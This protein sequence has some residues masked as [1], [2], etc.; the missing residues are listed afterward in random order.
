MI[1]M[2]RFLKIQCECGAD[3]IV[4]GDAKMARNCKKCG[5]ELV[6][7]RG[8]RAKITARIVEVLS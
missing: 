4:Y 5:K 2:A 7:P 6:T 3:D 8:G 1:N